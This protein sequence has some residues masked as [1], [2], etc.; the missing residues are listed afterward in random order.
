MPHRLAATPPPHRVIEAWGAEQPPQG[1]GWGA[2]G[3]AAYVDSQR[4]KT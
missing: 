3:P 2:A 4:F 1:D